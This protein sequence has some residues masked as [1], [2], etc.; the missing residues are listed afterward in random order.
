[1]L[2]SSTPM[3]QRHRAKQGI[4]LVATIM[5]ALA[6]CGQRAESPFEPPVPVMPEIVT[7][8]EVTPEAQ[9]PEPD[10][11]VTTLRAQVAELEQQLAECRGA[12]PPSGTQTAALP[13]GV[14]V[15]EPA[16]GARPDAGTRAR[17]ARQDPPSLIDTILGPADRRRADDTIE[18]PNPAKVLLGP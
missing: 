7:P 12:E 2:S 17:R 1:M 6:G 13:E 10:D 18:L 15:P 5:A 14:D 16:G 11:E 4:A 8:V 3:T 9:E